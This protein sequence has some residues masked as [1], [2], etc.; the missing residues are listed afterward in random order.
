MA[1]GDVYFLW[2]VCSSRPVVVNDVLNEW[3]GGLH[4]RD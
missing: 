1:L 4:L 2:F 3:V